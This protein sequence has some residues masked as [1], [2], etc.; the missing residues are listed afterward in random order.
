MKASL[1][2]R[3]RI[4]CWLPY[5]MALILAVPPSSLA[6]EIP[7]PVPS[8]PTVQS[9]R[10]VPLAGHGEMNDLDRKIMAPLVVQVLDQNARPVIGADVVFR[11]PL[12][13]PSASFPNQ[14]NSLTVKSN[15]D[16]QAAAV[17]W[18]AN[19]VAG[20]FEVRVTATRRNEMGEAVIPMT[21]AR[22]VVAERKE[23]RKRWWSS[24]WFKVGLVA[25]A[26]GAATGIVLAT[27]NGSRP[28][29]IISPGSP[30]IGG[31]Q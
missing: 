31:V 18:T 26:A 16:G 7:K 17:G 1:T 4:R 21:N 30:S 8:T 25:G 9:L 23:S 24:P 3:L 13:G 28:T 19:G 22:G 6:Q 15:A 12:N 27:R 5:L 11:F 10:V 2:Q 20:T 29:V 14:Q